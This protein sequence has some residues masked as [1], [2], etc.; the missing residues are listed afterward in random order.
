MFAVNLPSM[1]NRILLI[2]LLFFCKTL[3]L[4]Q[5]IAERIMPPEGYVR[6]E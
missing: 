5:T 2:F 3:L 6:T 1:I 4:G